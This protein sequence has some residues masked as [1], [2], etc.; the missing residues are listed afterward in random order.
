M[1]PT[2]QESSLVSIVP[3][4]T[5]SEVTLPP[6]GTELRGVPVHMGSSAQFTGEV[7][8]LL[9]SRLRLAALVMASA[10]A[11]FFI[12]GLVGKPTEVLG[13]S[14]S[15][16][17]I[18]LAL[19]VLNAGV[20]VVL[21]T[22]L[23]FS[24]RTLRALEL[25]LFGL[26]AVFFAWLQHGQ[27][28]QGG[29]TAYSAP[30]HQ[31]TVVRLANYANVLRWFALVII[32]GAFIPNTWQRCSLIISTIAVF[33]V[34]ITV[35]FIA[36]CPL[37]GPLLWPYALIDTMLFMSIAAAVAIF[38]SHKLIALH[39]EAFEMRQLGQYRLKERLGFGG[40]GEVYLAEH[41]LLRRPCAIKL[42][43]GDR[44]KDRSHLLR[45][46]REV[47]QTARLTHWNTIEIYDYG[48]TEDGTFYY[49][50]EYLPGEDLQELVYRHGPLPPARVIHILRQ[51]CAA[52]HEAHGVGLI[53][54]DIKPNNVILCERGG[55]RDVVKLLDFG[56]VQVSDFEGKENKITRQGAIAG[57]PAYMSPEQAKGLDQVDARSDVY[58]VGAVAY[59]LLTGKP[60][61]ERDTAIEIIAAHLRDPVLPP[62]NL[63]PE[64]P[65]DLQQVIMSCLEK[66]PQRRPQ[67][68]QELETAL[69]GCRDANGWT[70]DH[71]A[72]W[73][74]GHVP[75][76]PESNGEWD[77]ARAETR[78]YVGDVP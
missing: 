64:L 35:W 47:Q 60:P 11:A 78:A 62:R 44:A 61:F 29:A 34:S 76:A 75:H 66:N 42:I 57:S 25:G 31:E 49:V 4:M 48:H 77:A 59:Y 54:R 37:T 55:V 53:H 3:A 23:Q 10:G 52:L 65:V 26:M 43:R 45:F 51:M 14:G 24:L 50:M 30:G 39:K 19:I 69:S 6:R 20:A 17:L 16:V 27:M 41:R 40:M 68:A 56:L 74:T 71:A 46:E 22:R 36:M 73:W 15:S 63:R 7:Q 1:K 72:A 58:S 28:C 8:H 9:R 21:F 2:R 5:D 38:G 13:P 67:S 18:R 70:S 33:P 32:Y 12:W